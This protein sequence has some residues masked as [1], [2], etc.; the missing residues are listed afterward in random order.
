[1]LFKNLDFIFLQLWTWCVS[2]CNWCSRKLD[3]YKLGEINFIK[4]NIN[5]LLDSIFEG[6]LL[7]Y[8]IDYFDIPKNL[9]EFIIYNSDSFEKIY[10]HTNFRKL[11]HN[12]PKNINFLYQRDLD[13]EE[14]LFLVKFLI[15][16]N[17]QNN[18]EFI[19]WYDREIYFYKFMLVLKKYFYF[20]I[21]HI[22][23]GVSFNINN[24]T[25]KIFNKL[26]ERKKLSSCFFKN[27]IYCTDSQV[28]FKDDFYISCLE[29]LLNWY[30]KI[31]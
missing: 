10:F 12:V 21:K 1:M 5:K 6:K 11:K 8:N 23:N 22:Y 29:V 9:V 18:I 28:E 2:N 13:E 27:N 25:I 7:I 30:I 14:I 26:W 16:N 17:L 24:N 15:N 31:S 3:N 4:N 20:S 19:L